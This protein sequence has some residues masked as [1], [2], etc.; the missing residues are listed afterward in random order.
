MN[1][2]NQIYMIFTKTSTDNLGIYF[3]FSCN[4]RQMQNR[5]D[6]LWPNVTRLE[7]KWEAFD[8]KVFSTVK[9]IRT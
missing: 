1:K 4:I 2:L 9:Q 8:G 6:N 5:L 7:E 3:D